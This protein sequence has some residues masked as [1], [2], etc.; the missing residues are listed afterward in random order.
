MVSIVVPTF[1]RKS[2]LGVCI[3]SV[4]EQ[5]HED[6]ELIIV[7]DGSEDGTQEF[8]Q[9]ISRKDKRIIYLEKNGERGAPSSRNLGLQAARG[10]FVVFLDSDDLLAPFCLSQRLNYIGRRK[11]LDFA[12]FPQLLFENSPGDMN[13]LVNIP[14]DEDDLSRFLTIGQKIDVPWVN[15]SSIWKRASL[16][17]FGVLWNESVLKFQ[18]IQFHTDAIISGMK[19]EYAENCLPDCY[20]RKHSGERIARIGDTVEARA[21]HE[22]FLFEMWEKICSSGLPKERYRTRLFKC[23]YF[24]CLAASVSKRPYLERCRIIIKLRARGLITN[25]EFMD[26]F[27]KSSLILASSFSD[28]LRSRLDRSFRRRAETLYPKEGRGG[29][30]RHHIS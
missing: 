18:D 2:L 29:L 15:G 6:W 4:L 7:D 10:E 19:Y 24:L 5:D 22:K 3:G 25:M 14:T 13:I 17:S 9:E 11:D 16:R 12:V 21:S 1:N 20:W 30:A 23:I 28:T 27:A 8:L 26:L